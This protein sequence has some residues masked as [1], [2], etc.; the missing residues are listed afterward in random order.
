MYWPLEP[1]CTYAGHRLAGT[2]AVFLLPVPAAE[3]GGA[4]IQLA[5]S[6]LELAADARTGDRPV[7]VFP[8]VD[9]PIERLVPEQS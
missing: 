6:L 9:D 1:A 7:A 4:P 8:V 5:P 2:H 3:K